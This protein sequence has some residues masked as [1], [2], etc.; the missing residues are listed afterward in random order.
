MHTYIVEEVED[1]DVNQEKSDKIVNDALDFLAK[2]EDEAIAGYKKKIDEIKATITDSQQPANV[3]L[4]RLIEE[5]AKIEK[6][7]TEHKAFLEGAK[8]NKSLKFI[9]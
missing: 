3:V 7:E 5:L 1:A 4:N 6:E 8:S 9:R 2:D